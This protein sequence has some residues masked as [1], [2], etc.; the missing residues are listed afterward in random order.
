MDDNLMGFT[1]EAAA[2]PTD[3]MDLGG[4]GGVAMPMDSLAG[5][6][7][8]SPV[9]YADP[10]QG[11]PVQDAS[12]GMCG[13]GGGI[14]EMTALRE[15]EA[16]HEQE[17][18]ETSRKEDTEKAERRKAASEQLREWY[19]ERDANNQKRLT[20]NRSEEQTAETARAEAMQPGANPWERVVDLIDT[21]ARTA[22]PA[23]ELQS[24]S[25]TA[26]TLL[27]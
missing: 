24:S 3:A 12:A 2:S 10:F 16:K 21:N 26:S 7:A 9:A 19:E 15:W 6:M 1:G 23:A 11:M 18:E 13:G 8:A 25:S 14:P 20:T 27:W 4:A 17:L 5:G 22:T